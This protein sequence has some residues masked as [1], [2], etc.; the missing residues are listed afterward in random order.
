MVNLLHPDGKP[1]HTLS[2][3]MRRAVFD[4]KSPRLDETKPQMAQPPP[5]SH[6]LQH[7]VNRSSHNRAPLNHGQHRASRVDPQKSLLATS[8]WARS[9]TASARFHLLAKSYWDV[10]IRKLCRLL[11]IWD[12]YI[13]SLNSSTFNYWLSGKRCRAEQPCHTSYVQTELWD[14]RPRIDVRLSCGPCPDHQ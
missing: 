4:T 7:S 6:W 14:T 2:V 1:A 5:A 10:P 8:F 13:Q 12:S 3:R 11:T 9:M